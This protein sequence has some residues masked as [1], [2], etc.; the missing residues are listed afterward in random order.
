MQC[1]KVWISAVFVLA[2]APLVARGADFDGSKTLLCSI[3]AVNE[4]TA[5]DGCQNSTIENIGMPQFLKVDA[6]NKTVTPAKPIDGRKPTAIER[7]ERVEG[8]LILQGAEPGY[9]RVHDGLGWSAAISE[10]T[11]K[12][13]FTA[14]G[15]EVAFVAF[16]ACI[17]Q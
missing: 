3:N 17:A 16:G 1:V 9:E 11:G 8:K 2:A 13:I 5:N 14:S 4:C 6:Q 15:D 12:L 7:I 10:Q